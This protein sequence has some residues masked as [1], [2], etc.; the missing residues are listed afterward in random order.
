MSRRSAWLLKS[1]LDAQQND[2]DIDK[3]R[4]SPKE[5]SGISGEMLVSAGAAQSVSQA[6][7]EFR[8]MKNEPT[9]PLH[10]ILDQV[11]DIVEE[12]E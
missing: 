5:N 7:S 9:T 2:D 3:G 6:V 4:T 1:L 11:K 8:F 12:S 10:K